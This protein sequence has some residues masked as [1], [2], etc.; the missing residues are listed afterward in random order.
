MKIVQDRVEVVMLELTE[1]EMTLISGGWG[2]YGGFGGFG[3]S[4]P[5][6]SYSP[7]VYAQ[8]IYTPCV[9]AQP[10]YSPC[11]GYGW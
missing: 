8:P 11:Y 9:Y 10:V 5:C 6:Y 1:E 3:Y 4:S 7:C 2:G